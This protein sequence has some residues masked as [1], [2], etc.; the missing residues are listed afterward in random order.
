MTDSKP[1]TQDKSIDLLFQKLADKNGLVRQHAR[2]DLIEI[3]EPA[4]P[5]LIK[6]LSHKNKQVQWESAKALID[7]RSPQ[8]APALV[9][10]LMDDHPSIRWLSAE[11][12]IALGKNC[13]KPLLKELLDNYDSSWLRQGAHHVL[14][15]L[16]REDK[17]NPDTRH[18]LEVLRS[19][20]SEETVLTAA[21]R[22]KHSIQ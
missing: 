16:E 21:Q 11:A 9:Q 13:I 2:E 1:D 12:L 10:S 15:A 17:L 20:D 18:L 4:V 3:G 22:A 19:F 7:I 8:A 6:G 5:T 14:H